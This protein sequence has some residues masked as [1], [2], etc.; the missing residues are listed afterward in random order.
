MTAAGSTSLPRHGR[1]AT[2]RATSTS[3][4]SGP[5]S[6]ARAASST[7]ARTRRSWSSPAPSRPAGSRWRSRTAGCASSRRAARASSW[8]AVE[9]VTFSG[10]YAAEQGQPVY[11]VTERC[12]FRLGRE[13]LELIEVAPGIDIERDI[14]AHMAFR[15]IDPRPARYGRAHLPPGADG[16]GGDPDRPAASTTGSPTTRSATS[17]SSTSRACMSATRMTSS[18]SARPSSAAAGRSA[19]GS[20]WWS[21][22]TPSASP[23]RWST[24]T[25]PWSRT[26]STPTTPRSPA[27]RPAPS[28]G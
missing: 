4:A 23:R 3:A 27:T 1:D 20:R 8:S 2:R 24:P 7:S 16:A 11:Y 17:C 18:A 10:A 15:P 28:C 13:G 12:V 6:R 19:A 22:T 21:T 25:R 26:W 14:L 9:Q 5:S